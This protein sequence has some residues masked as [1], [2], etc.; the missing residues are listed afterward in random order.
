MARDV[1]VGVYKTESEAN[2][3]VVRLL[4]AGYD[5]DDISI[6][7]KDPER[8]EHLTTVDETATET[9]DGAAAGA[10]TGG[11]IGGLGGLL[12]GLGAL[13]IPGIG[14]IVAAGPIAGAIGGV[15]AGGAVGG[16]IGALV[17]LGV[18]EEE[19]RTYEEN[20]RQGDILVV[21]DADQEHYN[22]VN[23]IFNLNEEDYYTRYPRPLH[24][25][26]VNPHD[27][28]NMY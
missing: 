13:A 19:A 1:V 10:L 7:A 4:E 12:L 26:R 17:N 27:P 15:L 8:F 24:N 14:P 23:D 9:A 5:R 18:D 11:A 25:P 22:Q 6:V 28:N 20:L 3:A 21:V 2:S 16:L